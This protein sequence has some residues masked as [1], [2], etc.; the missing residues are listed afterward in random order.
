MVLNE[1]A[2]LMTEAAPRMREVSQ[3]LRQ[4]NQT[5]EEEVIGL[6]KQKIGH[7]KLI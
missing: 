7:E 5:N 1:L 6:Y 2:D 3:N 4:E